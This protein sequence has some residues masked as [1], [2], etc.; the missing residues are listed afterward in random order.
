MRIQSVSFEESSG[1]VC[2]FVIGLDGVED[3]LEYVE[4]DEETQ[5]KKV[6][7]IVKYETGEVKRYDNPCDIGYDE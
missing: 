4:V 6:Y 1:N 3:I 2:E 7:Y 5:E